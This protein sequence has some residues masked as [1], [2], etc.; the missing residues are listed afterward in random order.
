[1]I[2]IIS[3][4]TNNYSFTILNPGPSAE[5][6]Q[7]SPTPGRST[8]NL[9]CIPRLVQQ[10]NT[11]GKSCIRIRIKNSH[12]IMFL[13]TWFM[14]HS[15]FINYIH[16]IA[17]IMQLQGHNPSQK[18]VLPSMIIAYSSDTNTPF[19]SQ[20]PCQQKTYTQ[21]KQFQEEVYGLGFMNL[22]S[23][24]FMSLRSSCIIISPTLLGGIKVPHL[25]NLYSTFH[26]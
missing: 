3:C 1:M 4:F 19:S 9:K 20:V 2:L 6:H 22:G 10:K 26:G 11:K 8:C 7:S 5:H 25:I 23:L 12:P 14:F 16:K 13:R 21:L 18:E 15:D 17:F 24:G